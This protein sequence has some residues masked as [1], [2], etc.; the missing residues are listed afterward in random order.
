MHKFRCAFLYVYICLGICIYTHMLYMYIIHTRCVDRL[1]LSLQAWACV[2]KVTQGSSFQ[3]VASCRYSRFRFL[4]FL[5]L[6]LRWKSL[7]C[8]WV[9]VTPGQVSFS[10]ILKPRKTSSEKPLDFWPALSIMVPLQSTPERDPTLKE[11]MGHVKRL[12]GGVS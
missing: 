11:N 4:K 12:V 8:L 6:G 9:R 3:S 7:V 2:P 10:K 1:P 5:V